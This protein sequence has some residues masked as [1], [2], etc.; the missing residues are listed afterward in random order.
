[1]RTVLS[2]YSVC[3][4]VFSK[5]KTRL[6]GGFEIFKNQ[7]HQGFQK[8]YLTLRKI[9]LNSRYEFGTQEILLLL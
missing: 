8:S 2:V 3:S 5:K 4:R 7:P 9:T 1:M 6:L